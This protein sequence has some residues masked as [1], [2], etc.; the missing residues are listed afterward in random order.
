MNDY[1][2]EH[3]KTAMPRKSFEIAADGKS[4]VCHVCGL[5]SYNLDD[6]RYRYCSNCKLFHED[7]AL[8]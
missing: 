8:I 6:V 4:I 2:G 5:R 3:D 1:E 7:G